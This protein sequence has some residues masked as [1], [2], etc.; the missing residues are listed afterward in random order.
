MELLLSECID[1]YVLHLA[2]NKGDEV[3]KENRTRLAY[4]LP[5]D[6]LS[7]EVKELTTVVVTGIAK[8]DEAGNLTVLANGVYVQGQR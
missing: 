8:R 5:P 4:N 3:A 1:D 2:E 7:T 6:M